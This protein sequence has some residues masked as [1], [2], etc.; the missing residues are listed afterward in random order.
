MNAYVQG[1]WVAGQNVDKTGFT[2]DPKLQLNY[3]EFLNELEKRGVTNKATWHLEGIGVIKGEGEKKKNTDVLR[4]ISQ[5]DDSDC[6]VS[7]LLR[8]D[9]PNRHWGSLCLMAYAVGQG[10]LCYIIAS[11]DCVAWKSHFVWHP[12]IK[13]YNDVEE[14]LNDLERDANTI[15]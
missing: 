8:D 15:C 6:V 12:L 4:N 1:D 7:Y 2:S 5:I 10:K 14:C 11:E 13:H 9:P 3:K